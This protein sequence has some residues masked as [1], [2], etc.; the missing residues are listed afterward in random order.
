M[1]MHLLKVYLTAK[2][3]VDHLLVNPKKRD[4]SKHLPRGPKVCGSFKC[5]YL[6]LYNYYLNYVA[7]LCIKIYARNSSY[8]IVPTYQNVS[9]LIKSKIITIKS[10]QIKIIIN[11]IKH[12]TTWHNHSL[13]EWYK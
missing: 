6:Y 3:L 5:S 7:H 9:I 1:Q 10:I 4:I 11:L 12:P 8:K 2:N 13:S